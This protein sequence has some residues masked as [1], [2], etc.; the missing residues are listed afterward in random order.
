M[1]QELMCG[2]ALAEGETLVLELEAELWARSSNPFAQYVGSIKK[3]IAAI[4]GFKQ[5]GFLVI[6][7]RRILEVSTQIYC[8][9][10]KTGHSIKYVLPGSVKEIGYDRTTTLGVFC[11][12]Y[13][14]YYQGHTQYT[15]ILLKGAD[16]AEAQRIVKAFY[17]VIS[18]ANK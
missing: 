2:L 7:D 5:K 4:F 15:R 16:E 1:A 17:S 18:K 6:T 3:T 12:A 9:F 13:H 14:L 8:Y 11:P 10:F